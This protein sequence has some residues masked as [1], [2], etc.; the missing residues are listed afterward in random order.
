MNERLKKILEQIDIQRGMADG[1]EPDYSK[2]DDV[3]YGDVVAIEWAGEFEGIVD[4]GYVMGFPGA[5][6]SD[7]NMGG[8]IHVPHPQNP[9]GKDAADAEWITLYDVGT[10]FGI[11]RIRRICSMNRRVQQ[12]LTEAYPTTKS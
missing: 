10:M 1:P 5:E 8:V 12:C 7:A 3:S 6:E 2:L 11:K 9:G 4:Y